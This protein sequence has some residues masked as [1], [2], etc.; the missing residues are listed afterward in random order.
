VPFE[1]PQHG[2]SL[3]DVA[4]RTGLQNENFQA[5]PETIRRAEFPRGDELSCF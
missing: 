5:V 4:K 2:Q 1:Q 3:D